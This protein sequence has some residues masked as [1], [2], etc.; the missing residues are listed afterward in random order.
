MSTPTF[1]LPTGYATLSWSIPTFTESVT[2]LGVAVLKSVSYRNQLELLPIDGNTGFVAGFTEMKAGSAGA[3]GTKFDTEEISVA[4]VSG[5]H[6]T[7]TWPEPGDVI[8]ISGVTGA[9]AK[10]NGDWKVMAENQA[11]AR[12]QEAEIGFDLKRWADIDLTP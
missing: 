10:L 2:L 7:K 8:T 4:A 3:G 12:K 11:F 1:K 5:T 9:F 6:A